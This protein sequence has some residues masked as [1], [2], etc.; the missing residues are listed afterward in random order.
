M[1]LGVKDWKVVE[2]FVDGR[3][4]DG[5]KLHTDGNRPDGYWLG[6]T[7]IAEKV[8]GHKIRFNDLG[9]RSAQ[10]VQRAVR[11][12]APAFQMEDFPGVN[13]KRRGRRR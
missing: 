7:G 5:H 8:D 12:M 3:A 6:G 1:R 13:G 10:S 4:L 9:S 11:G 2:A